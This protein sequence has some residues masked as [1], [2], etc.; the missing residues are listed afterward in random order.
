MT[1]RTRH[2]FQFRPTVRGQLTASAFFKPA[3]FF[4]LA[5]A[6]EASIFQFFDKA[7]PV[8]INVFTGMSVK[9]IAQNG[10]TALDSPGQNHN[11][12]SRL[13]TGQSF[14]VSQAGGF[15]PELMDIVE[16]RPFVT[17]VRTTDQVRVDAHY[18]VQ[19]IAFDTSRFSI[20]ASGHLG[21]NVPMAVIRVDP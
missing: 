13:L 18:V 16:T 1:L 4:S 7:G 6:G 5:C 3:F 12:F 21:L 2:R 17:E 15:A 20:D 9:V 10:A 14:S 19:A 8:T 11:V